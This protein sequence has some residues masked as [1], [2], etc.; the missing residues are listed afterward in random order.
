MSYTLDS[1]KEALIEYGS[2][3]MSFDV[4]TSRNDI[5]GMNISRFIHFN[6]KKRLKIIDQISIYSDEELGNLISSST[7]LV[8]L[9]RH[10]AQSMR[11]S[12]TVHPIGNF[13]IA[14]FGGKN[15][16]LVKC[17]SS[18]MKQLLLNTNELIDSG[19]YNTIFDYEISLEVTHHGPFSQLPVVFIEV[20]SS[21]AQWRDLEACRLIADAV[22]KVD[23][24]KKDQNSDWVSVIGF[25][26]NHY[27]SKFTRYMLE[28]EFA[29]GHICA[30]H[31][32]QWLNRNLVDQMIT[33]TIPKPKVVLFDK[34]S[35]KRKQQI[36]TWL[37]DFDLEVKQ[38]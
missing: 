16:T 7:T 29:F 8:Y 11:P 30:K 25:G 6:L 36:K 13:G 3:K 5:A 4:L 38:V 18:L 35:M 10:S 14:E 12:F 33:N 1:I 32:I 21:E 2:R 22:N 15:N 9:S 31:S 20:G 34:K 26:G 23:F 28:T 27:A 19:E 17:N 37:S 24:N